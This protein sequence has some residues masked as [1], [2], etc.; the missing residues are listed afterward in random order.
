MYKK[1][2]AVLFVFVFIQQSFAQNSDFKINVAVS[3]LLAPAKVTL[4]LRENNQWT[5][6]PVEANNGKFIISGKVEEPAFAYLVL[7]YGNELDKSPRLGNVLELFV[8][9]SV[10]EVSANDSLVNATV[11][12]TAVQSDFIAYQKSLS[13]WKKQKNNSVAEKDQIITQFIKDHPKSPV[14]IFA[15]QNLALDGT[16]SL[17]AAEAQPLLELLSPELKAS[18]TGKSL[19]N[20]IAIALSTSSGAIAPNFTQ[21]DTSN[22]PVTLSSLRGKYV[23][24]DFWA[25][26]CK[27]CRAEN[28]ELVKTF[29]EFKDKNFTIISVSLDSNGKS[30]KKAI[31][32]DQLTWTHVSDLQFWK[33][34]VALLY[35]VKTVPQNFLIDP[36]GKIIASGL[37]ASEL[38]VRLT[39]FIR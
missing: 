30:W 26:W 33:N 15:I 11:K 5:E 39:E 37:K 19:S 17:N 29:N 23:L 20:D 2:L 7:K 16:F 27:P 18:K 4:T 21:K 8:N 38:K 34:E 10:I 32:K 25:S 1:C 35:G 9:N 24:I 14:N 36:S 28:P 31:V 13:E 6:Y 22:V 12:G 3:S